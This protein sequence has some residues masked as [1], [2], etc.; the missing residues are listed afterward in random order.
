MTS[1]VARAV[2]IAG[3][4]EPSDLDV[5]AGE[6]VALVGPNGGGKTSLLRAL[7]RIESASGVVAI[8]GENVDL[9]PLARRR[10]L[11][12]FLPASRD[13]TWPISARDVIAL[14]LDRPDPGRIEQLI[15]QFELEKLADRPVNRLSTGE[16]ARVLAARALVGNPRILLLDE[17]LSNLDPYWVL[18]FLSIFEA[19]AR[20]GQ[21]VLVALHD[22]S[23]LPHFNRAL[24]IADG[25]VRMD[26]APPS[27]VAS[28][29]FE[30]IFRIQSANGGWRIRR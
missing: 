4:L 28:E 19:A 9:A 22:L 1:L 18:R 29:R 3:R 7:A 24:L 23:Q 26:E 2:G 13:V 17:P 15:A 30:E 5:A 14:G 11:L 8:D 27:L 10:H 16:R 25:K 20:S 21:A 12:S 6:L